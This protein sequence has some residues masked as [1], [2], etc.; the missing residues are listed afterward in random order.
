MPLNH[1]RNHID[2]GS[3]H[4]TNACRYQPQQAEL[5]GKMGIAHILQ[6]ILIPA[7]SNYFVLNQNGFFRGFQ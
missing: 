7:K 4:G 6:I 5:P 2:G 3:Q 1:E